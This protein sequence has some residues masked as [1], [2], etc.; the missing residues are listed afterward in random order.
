MQKDW[1]KSK[2]VISATV[3]LVAGLA[4]EFGYGVEIMPLVQML[5]TAGMIYGFRDALK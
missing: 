2:T 4:V 1:Y 3:W 5:A